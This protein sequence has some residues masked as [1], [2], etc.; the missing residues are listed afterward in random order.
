MAGA[1][2]VTVEL[3]AA[4]AEAAAAVKPKPA[5]AEKLQQAAQLAAE[6]ESKEQG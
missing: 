6:P 2:S 1:A 3:L 4:A 5:A